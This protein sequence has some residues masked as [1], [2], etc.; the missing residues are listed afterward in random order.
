M[1]GTPAAS[2][3]WGVTWINW[4]I[5]TASFSM[6][7]NDSLT[8]FFNHTRGLRQGD[9]LSP[10]LFVL[11]MEVFSLLVKKAVSGGFLKRYNLKGEEWRCNEFI[12]RVV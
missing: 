1:A 12:L 7:I 5:S 10:Y 9:P 6:H 11:G 2:R 8:G 4:C 3:G